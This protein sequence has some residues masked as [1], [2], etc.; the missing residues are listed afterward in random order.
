MK[1][2]LKLSLTYFLIIDPEGNIILLYTFVFVFFVASILNE[3]FVSPHHNKRV[4]DR[5]KEETGGGE[6]HRLMM[7]L[8]FDDGLLESVQID[9]VHGDLCAVHTRYKLDREI[10]RLKPKQHGTSLHFYL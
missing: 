6:I 8:L 7:V 9:G 2:G 3:R 4:S 5:E 10:R 1:L